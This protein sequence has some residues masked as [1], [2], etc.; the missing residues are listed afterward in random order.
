MNGVR[1]QITALGWVQSHAEAF[2]GDPSSVTVFGQSAGSV[3]VCILVASPAARGL[4]KRAILQSGPCIGP[5]SPGSYLDGLV[6]KEMM[7]TKLNVSTMAELQ[8]VPVELL[9]WPLAFQVNL[10]FPGAYI[11][12]KPDGMQPAAVMSQ[13]PSAIYE[14]ASRGEAQLNA[15]QV[16]IGATNR[17]GLTPY[18]VGSLVPVFPFEYAAEVAAYWAALN[19]LN[20]SSLLGKLITVVE[21]LEMYPIKDFQGHPSAA[22]VAADGDFTVV[23]PLRR[24]ADLMTQAGLPTYEYSYTH[25]S[26]AGCDEAA[27]VGIVP[28]GDEHWASHS[29]ELPYVFGSHNISFD[30]GCPKTEAERALSRAMQGYWMSFARSGVP[31]GAKP[32]PLVRNNDLGKAGGLEWPRGT[33]QLDL[34]APGVIAGDPKAPYCGFWGY[35][36]RWP[37]G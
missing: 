23:C 7:F 34:P 28:P 31:Q 20:R 29:S 18:Y 11:D 30:W 24:L 35:Q 22:F 19:L 10:L 9:Q 36:G 16:M 4:F 37:G 6:A 8:A 5:W 27:S 1:D 32:W 15:E 2:G 33:M 12:A 26:T 13:Q 25:S 21:V 17:D 3:S 14:A